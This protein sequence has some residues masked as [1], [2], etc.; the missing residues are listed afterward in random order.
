MSGLVTTLVLPKRYGL[1]PRKIVC[2]FL[3]QLREQS[4]SGLHSI[5]VAGLAIPL[6][7][8]VKLLGVT[9]HMTAP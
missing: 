4:F 2:H 6:Y 9:R 8:H 5:D 7:S 1:I 3:A